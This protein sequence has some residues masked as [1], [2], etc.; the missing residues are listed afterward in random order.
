MVFQKYI[1]EYLEGAGL[2]V[3]VKVII[4]IDLT[5]SAFMEATNA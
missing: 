4:L 3:G 5:K 2:T 1:S